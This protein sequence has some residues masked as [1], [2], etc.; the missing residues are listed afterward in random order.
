MNKG[1]KGNKNIG[2]RGVFGEDGQ[3]PQKWPGYKGYR[4]GHFL[5]YYDPNHK[6]MFLN[7]HLFLTVLYFLSRRESGRQ[8]AS[9]KR[10]AT[11]LIS[12]IILGGRSVARYTI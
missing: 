8:S 10:P 4:Q 2:K 6:I 9:S 3:M 12:E 5:S 7:I 1:K 11:C